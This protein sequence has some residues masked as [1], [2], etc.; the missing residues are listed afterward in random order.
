LETRSQLTSLRSQRL[1]NRVNLH[2]ALGG[3]FSSPPAEAETEADDKPVGL[4]KIFKR[5]TRASL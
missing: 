3:G 4:R 2:L 5:K 1:E